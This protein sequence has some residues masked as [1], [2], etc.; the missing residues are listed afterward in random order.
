MNLTQMRTKIRYEL[1]DTDGD[2]WNL[3]ELDRAVE[4]SVSLMSRL[5]PKR[6]IAE[7]TIVLDINSE[8]FSSHLDRFNKLIKLH[9]ELKKVS[10][11]L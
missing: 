4:K 8:A 10:H 1:Q 2:V 11:R 7:T 5:I 3:N 9:Q 6:S